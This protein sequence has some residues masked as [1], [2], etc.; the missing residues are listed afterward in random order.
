MYFGQNRRERHGKYKSAKR[1]VYKLLNPEKLIPPF[2]NYMNSTFLNET[3][4]LCVEFK[5]S[6]EMRAFKY[7]DF[8]KFI[9]KWALEP[10]SIPYIKPTDNKRHRYYPDLFLEFMNGEKFIV[11]IK[12]SSERT[13]PV[14]PMRKTVSTVQRYAKDCLTYATNCAKWQAAEQFCKLRGYHFT[15][16]T[17]KELP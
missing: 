2:D 8:N 12:A 11:E 3:G 4:D 16:L 15:V 13:K 14:P 6:L 9:K 10:F 5:S 7:A 17:E 1:G